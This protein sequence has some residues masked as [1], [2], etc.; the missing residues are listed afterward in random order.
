MSITLEEVRHVAK[1]SRLELDETE[2]LSLQGELNILLGHF[3]DIQT[4]DTTGIEPKAQ[5]VALQNVWAEDFPIIGLSRDKAMSNAAR[6]KAGL[7]LVP[8][9]IE[10]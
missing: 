9:I 4:M 8:A 6:S 5:A 2:M 3:G 7:F 10:D 1:L